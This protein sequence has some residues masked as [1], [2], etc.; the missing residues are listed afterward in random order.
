VSR[1]PGVWRDVVGQDSALA[2]LRRAV[3]DPAFMTHAWLITGPP[4]SGRS[5]AA[6][7][8]AAA[9]ECPERGCGQCRECRTAYDG[10]HADV[11]LVSTE[12]LQIKVDRARELVQL[13]ARAPSVGR[14]RV[15]V[16]EDADRL[17]EHS[18]N[19]LLKAIEEP[20][21][22]TVW[23]LCAPSLEDV[24]ITLRSRSRHVRLRTPPVE[25]VAELLHRRDGIEEPMA[26]YAARAA[27]SHIGLARRLARDEGARIRRRQV[28]TL[29]GRITGVGEAVGAAADLMAIA[30]EERD[31]AL[32]ER[33]ATERERLLLTLGADPAARTQPPHVRAQVAAME[34]EQK[35][36]A[37]RFTR[38]VVDRTLVDLLSVYRDALVTRLGLGAALVNQDN[39]ALV[40]QVARAFTAEG[41]LGAM[42]A[43]G[44][45]RERIDAN[46]PP[47]L[48]LEAMAVSLQLPR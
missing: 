47:L 14:Y 31:A 42:D 4:G 3:D 39:S 9:L 11:D 36:R 38:D 2:L 20:S 27:Q 32:G 37:T 43:I 7:A 23:V 46:V 35:T 5:V 13:A 29:A 48:A 21:P 33:N 6:R 26:L 25:A 1:P 15:I 17:N 10:T 40:G 45:A 8:F 19:G 12:G 28:V 24:L 22:R 41:L 18:G 34:R 30:E 44:T 16:V